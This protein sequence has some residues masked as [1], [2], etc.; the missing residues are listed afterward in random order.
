ML[1][2]MPD[3]RRGKERVY[4]LVCNLYRESREYYAQQVIYSMRSLVYANIANHIP[5]DQLLADLDAAAFISDDV[6][7][8][9]RESLIYRAKELIKLAKWY[10]GYDPKNP[11]FVTRAEESIFDTVS[12]LTNAMEMSEELENLLVAQMI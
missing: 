9:A 10:L 6:K 5:T 1:R 4:D 7:G 2:A 8:E 3:T 11:N 12:I